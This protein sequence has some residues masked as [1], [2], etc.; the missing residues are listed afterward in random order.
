MMYVK[1]MVKRFPFAKERALRD[2]RGIF[3][4]GKIHALYGPNGSGKSTFLGCLA[5]KYKP[6]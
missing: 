2:T 6:T 4:Q 1:D 3:C 5:K